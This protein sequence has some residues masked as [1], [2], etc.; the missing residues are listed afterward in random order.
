MELAE[1]DGDKETIQSLL[2]TL[3]PEDL[4][5][6]CSRPILS[7]E[8]VREINY[9]CSCDDEKSAIKFNGLTDSPSS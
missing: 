3:L 5:S 1:R 7:T 9:Y 4:P 8:I 6:R 2:E